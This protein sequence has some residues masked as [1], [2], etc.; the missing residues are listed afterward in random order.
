MIRIAAINDIPDLLELE[1][2]SFKPEYRFNRDQ[3]CY[4]IRNNKSYF[5]VYEEDDGFIK[6]IT[7][8]VYVLNNGRLYSI[9]C[10]RDRGIGI[11]L[12]ARAE[13]FVSTI[14]NKDVIKLEV[15]KGNKK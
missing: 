14:L 5:R 1:N 7:G 11:L 3:F 2:M 15:K 12:L 13:E 4:D 9:A 10:H 6:W 8:Y